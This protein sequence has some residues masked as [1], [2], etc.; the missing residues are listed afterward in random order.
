MAAA[1][2]SMPTNNSP[3]PRKTVAKNRSS[4]APIRSRTAPMN[5]RKRESGEGNEVERAGPSPCAT[6]RR[7]RC[8]RC[9]GWLGRR[10]AR[11]RGQCRVAA[12]N[13]MPAMAAARGVR[14][15]L[16]V[17]SMSVSPH[18]LRQAMSRSRL[19]WL[20][21]RRP[22]G[23]RHARRAFRDRRRFAGLEP[24]I[25]FV[26]ATS[27]TAGARVG[28][29]CG[30]EGDSTDGEVTPVTCCEFDPSRRC[31]TDRR[32]SHSDR[33]RS[34]SS[35][36]RSMTGRASGATKAGYEFVAVAVG[37]P[38]PVVGMRTEPGFE[39]E[40]CLVLGE[41]SRR[42]VPAVC[43][44]PWSRARTENGDDGLGL[45]ASG[46][47]GP[48]AQVVRRAGRRCRRSRLRCRPSSEDRSGLGGAGVEAIEGVIGC[49]KIGFG[50]V[51][52]VGDVG[53]V[54]AGGVD[55]VVVAVAA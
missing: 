32:V 17:I 44:V 11:S 9:V 31:R 15:D 51:D 10:S 20:R 22:D 19:P 38:L 3:V 47:S 21:R 52:P 1:T 54:A 23:P 45:L 12:A 36:D 2:K 53:Q 42:D 16:L 8:R 43:F 18:L 6:G 5:H 4:A 37:G 41:A 28:A 26:A 13:A 48:D 30:G 24:H 34:G 50:L 35:I 25:R 46:H 7:A 14:N 33:P 39:V 49:D 40:R 55:L 29:R 27:S